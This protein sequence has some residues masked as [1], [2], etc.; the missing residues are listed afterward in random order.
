[1][2]NPKDL[3]KLKLSNIKQYRKEMRRIKKAKEQEIRARKIASG[4]LVEIVPLTPE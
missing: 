4:E 1:M 2:K 3:E